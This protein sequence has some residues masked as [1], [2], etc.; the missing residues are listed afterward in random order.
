V[1]TAAD[2]HETAVAFTRSFVR[3]ACLVCG[4]DPKLAASLDADPPPVS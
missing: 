1:C 2:P 3:H 4:W